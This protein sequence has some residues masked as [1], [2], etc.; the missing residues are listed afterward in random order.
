MVTEMQAYSSLRKKS[1]TK[2]IKFKKKS[3]V[4][5]AKYKPVVVVI[6]NPYN[7]ASEFAVIPC[8]DSVVR[9][10]HT[11]DILIPRSHLASFPGLWEESSP[12]PAFH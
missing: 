12:H 1:N 6:D 5:A 4:K 7:P 8:S 2:Q 11:L 3:V 10:A 9:T